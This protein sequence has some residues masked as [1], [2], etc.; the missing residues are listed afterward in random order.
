LGLLVQG[1]VEQVTEPVDVLVGHSLGAV[2][3]LAA[4]EGH[5]QLARAL[6]LE[7]PPS[8]A[9]SRD[10]RLC[11]NITRDAAL[12][13]TDRAQLIRREREGNPTW[14]DEDVERSVD[15]IAAADARAI[16]RGLRGPLR[17]NLPDLVAAAR[18]P[19][20]L[21]AAPLDTAGA[22]FAATG[23][24][25]LQEPDRAEV[26]RMLPKERAL[27]LQGRHCL[28]RDQPGRWVEEVHTFAIATLA[29]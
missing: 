5:P 21:L 18:V 23:G 25:A 4:A 13:R 1:V 15:A 7:D 8:S 26:L 10:S 17:W 29:A 2:T 6:V 11:A 16:V 24:T 28:H 3:A 19:V 9:V 20:L 12:I 22:G 27:V 14:L